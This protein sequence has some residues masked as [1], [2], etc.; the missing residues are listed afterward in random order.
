MGWIRRLGATL[1]TFAQR[2]ATRST[3]KPAF[4][5]SS[6]STEYIARRDVAGGGPARSRTGGS[7]A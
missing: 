4:I 7:A 3:K 1:R 5:S 6:A 2:R